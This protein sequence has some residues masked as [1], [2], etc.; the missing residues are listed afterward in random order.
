MV[1]LSRLKMRC[2]SHQNNL[3]SDLALCL[4]ARSSRDRWCRFYPAFG[5]GGRSCEG[6]VAIEVFQAVLARSVSG[7]MNIPGLL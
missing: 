5:Y 1:Y 6:R 2:F 7:F 3:A 4:D